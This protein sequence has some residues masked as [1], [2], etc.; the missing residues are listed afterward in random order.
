MFSQKQR[1]VGGAK[2]T[3]NQEEGS[4]GKKVNEKWNEKV[5]GNLF[6]KQE[7]VGFFDVT[8]EVLEGEDAMKEV[9]VNGGT[10]Y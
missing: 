4:R 1:G 7:F 3:G 5:S 9:E 2:T 10:R 6:R 8:G